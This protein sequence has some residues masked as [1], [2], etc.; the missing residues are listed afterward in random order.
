M[1]P[2]TV[3][4]FVCTKGDGQTKRVLSIFLPP[5]PLNEELFDEAIAPF[6]GS[7][8]PPDYV[9]I[10][11]APEDIAR[12]R[13]I[14]KAESSPR[15]RLQNVLPNVER[16]VVLIKWS[17]PSNDNIVG[18]T[19]AGTSLEQSITDLER[20]FSLSDAFLKNGGVVTAAT[21]THFTKPSGTHSQRFLR[22]ANL[23][24]RRAAS[25]QLAFWLYP[26]LS[27]RRIRRLIVD[28]SG[29]APVAFILAYERLRRGID[30]ELPSIES[31]AS[32][33]GLDSLTI[34]DPDQTIFLIS[35]STSGNLASK[36]MSKGALAQNIFTLFFLGSS[37]DGTVICELKDDRGV[38][39]EGIPVI[40]NHSTENCPDCK[41]HSYPIPLVGDQFRT[42]PA[43]VEELNILLSDFD[44]ATRLTLNRLVSTGAFKVFRSNGAR[45]MELYIDV[46]QLVYGETNDVDGTASINDIQMRFTRLLRRGMP[47]HLRRI[48]PTKYLG[49]ERF[50]KQARETLPS[51]V[52]SSVEVLLSEN[53]L[54]RPEDAE[55]AT[56]VVSGC[57]D[58]IYELMGI[59]RDLRTVQPG[60]NITYVSPVFRASSESERKRVE[61]NLTFGDQGPKTFSLFNVLTIDLPSCESNH[62]W[63]LEYDRLLEVQHWC[64]LNAIEV[65]T[66][67]GGR[68]TALRNAPAVGLINDVYW[69][70]PAG[71]QLN[72]ASDF[73]IIPTRDGSRKISQAD[74]FAIVTSLFHKYR[75]GVRKKPKLV[76][77]NYE[78]TV[79]APECFQRFSDGVLQASF[80]RAARGGEI[81]YGNCEKT[82]SERMFVFLMGEL[83]ATKH[84]G[85]PALIEYLIALL[86][87]RLT[88]HE[89]HVQEFLA[90]VVDNS[91][92]PVM[93]TIAQFI[94][95][96]LATP[97]TANLTR[98]SD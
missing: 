24:E 20:R 25:H 46:E 82:V 39:F 65:P 37:T 12:V 96:S 85:G 67:I 58:D 49:A 16:D 10:S 93:T 63:S 62:A 40:D 26:R 17:L 44:E 23:L 11:G 34:A 98:T 53:L 55:T 84:G 91:E 51:S 90:A 19:L 50:A 15:A 69:P 48:V 78:R 43:K 97:A 81:A 42:E 4:K 38:G 14:L 75:Q 77:R 7:G 6:L 60:G 56:L 94:L 59:S 95:A 57:M 8:E 87:G 61:S 29:I 89:E 76:S 36:L 54:P 33:G 35:A 9:H 52:Q 1:N 13:E 71:T 18:E 88:L 31:H 5:V 3:C 27:R 47:T 2:I 30:S 74:I 28:T 72:I 92:S 45:Q 83:A 73:T 64:D 68:I 32:Y 21:G 70:T 80:L 79:I 86:I 41:M 66:P 22:A